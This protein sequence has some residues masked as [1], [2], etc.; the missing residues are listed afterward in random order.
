MEFCYKYAY[1][2]K[3]YKKHTLHNQNYSIRTC[4]GIM[5]QETKLP[6]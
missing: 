6:E 2:K 3:P 5:A 4:H 1:S